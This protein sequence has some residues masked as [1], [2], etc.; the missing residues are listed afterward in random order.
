M[1]MTIQFKTELVASLIL[2][3]LISCSHD[4]SSEEPSFKEALLKRQTITWSFTDHHDT[5]ESV[6]SIQVTEFEYNTDNRLIKAGPVRF[7]YNEA[8]QLIA[9][10]TEGNI[11]NYYWTS[12]QLTGISTTDGYYDGGNFHDSTTFTYAG[13]TLVNS[14]STYAKTITEYIYLD[15]KIAAK[16]I[17]HSKAGVMYCDSLLYTWSNGNLISLQTCSSYPWSSYLY[18][19]EFAYDNRPSWMS[20]I[21]Y[22]AEY[23]LVRE[24]T[25]FYT[26]Y[27]LFYYDVIPWRYNCFNNPVEFVERTND[28]VKISPFHVSYNKQGYP[29]SIHASYFTIDFEYY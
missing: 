20:V 14:T 28:Q 15:Q 19:R 24:I 10:N 5:T 18:V 22:P 12:G 23:L 29:I 13:G 11:V 3:V 7:L 25:Q 4:D 26:A 1:K 2:L 16:Y 17:T 9:T 6:V 21:R 8:G 27:P